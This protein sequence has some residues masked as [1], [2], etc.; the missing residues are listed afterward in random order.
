M[1]STERRNYMR[2]NTIDK[3]FLTEAPKATE[4]QLA[5]AGKLREQAAL[6]RER[7]EE[8][9]QR[10]DTDG[11]VSQWASGITARK[12]DEKVRIL[13]NGG[14]QACSALFEGDRVV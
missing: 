13:E 9:S 11:F 12:L 5:Y 10:S 7:V 6:Y 1:D 14:Y 4:S 8:S 3:P 2:T